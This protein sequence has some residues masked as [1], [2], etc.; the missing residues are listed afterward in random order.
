MKSLNL[1]AKFYYLFF[2]VQ[3]DKKYMFQFIY[4]INNFAVRFT[5][6][7]PLA[8]IK[9]SKST[10]FIIDIPITAKNNTWSILKFD[11]IE[12]IQTNFSK[13]FSN[14]GNLTTEN[15]VLKSL[16]FSSHM[17]IRGLYLS[18]SIYSI[19]VLFYFT[20]MF[21]FSYSTDSTKRNECASS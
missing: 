21:I 3:D 20:Y 12:F 11:P 18:N 5:F 1:S 9:F 7:Y 13:Q 17:F 2:K 10:S 14:L 4:L 8:E 15:I 16:Q 6:K 19:K